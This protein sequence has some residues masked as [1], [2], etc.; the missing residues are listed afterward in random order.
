MIKISA[1][2]VTTALLAL[3]AVSCNSAAPETTAAVSGN[4]LGVQQISA[5]NYAIE[6][7]T[8]NSWNSGFQGYVRLKNINGDDVTKFKLRVKL[9][10]GSVSSGWGGTFSSA[11][12]SGFVTITNPD[13]LVHSPIKPGA[14]FE[15]GF[16]ANGA[17]TT[18][19]T[20]LLEINGVAITTGGGGGGTN[21][22]PTVSFSSP[23]AGATLPVGTTSVILKANA[24]DSDGTVSSVKFYNGATLV[25]TD[26]TAPYE[27]TVTG[28]T[29]GSYTFKATATDNKGA[30]TDSTVSV[31][32]AAV[33]GN[34]A[35]TV[36]ITS[37]VSGTVLPIGT[38]SV[39]VKATAADSDGTVASVKFYNGATLVSTDT[40]APFEAVISG[41]SAGSYTFK[42]TATDNKGA[43]TDATSSVTIDSSTGGGGG[44]TR[45][46]N[47]FIGAKWYINKEWAAQAIANG[48]AAIAGYNTAVWMDRIGAIAPTTPNTLGLRGHLD[49]ALAQGANVFTMVVYD[50]P[51]RDCHALA[52]NGELKISQNG[53]NRYKTEYITPLAA[54]LADPK[55]KNIRIIAVIEPDSLPNLVTN[56]SDAICQEA[57]G[58][59]GYVEATQYTLNSLYPI[60]NVYSY[61]DIGHS[62]WLGWD[63][64]LNGATTLIANAIKGTTNGVN[65]VAGFISNTANTTPLKEPFLD[66]LSSL[67]FPGSNG[68]LQ[69]RQAKYYEW[70]PFF[71]EL[72]FVTAWR[73]KMIGLGFPS[74]IGMLVDTSRNGWGGAGRPTAASTSTDLDTFVDQSRIDRR[75]HRGMWCN[76]ASGIG[77]RPTVAPEPGVDAYVWIKPPGE[78]DG[79]SQAGIIDPT[80]PAKGFDRFCDPTFVVPSNNKITGALPNAPHAGRWFAEEFKLL[81]K[82][83]YPPLQ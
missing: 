5:A 59:G 63:T 32:I 46:D 26:T 31:T 57:A 38:T 77:E 45:M 66:A 19:Q 28:L 53:F 60:T 20:E 50:L 49:A 80:D 47:P 1:K 55:Y 72:P 71:S 41:L 14:N 29:A 12:A 34:V 36:S 15:S 4:V 8:T 69:T 21:V 7:G 22:A 73:N 2:L 33:A 51:N 24:A 35:P 42:A 9:A 17:F 44:G 75:T 40:A 43:S 67:P 68:S 30:T 78:S 37:P 18:A 25:S 61:I 6:V 11:D 16:T 62:G 79:V 70:N 64:N 23:A 52:S 76:Q 54:I 81:I 56:T 48:G 27:A 82:N 83:A 13:Y 3:G 74:T 58:A 65:S 39:T 10:T